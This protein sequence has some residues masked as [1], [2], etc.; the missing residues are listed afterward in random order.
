MHDGRPAFPT[1]LGAGRDVLVDNVL[2]GGG[3][4]LRLVED[5]RHS[6][7]KGVTHG[8]LHVRLDHLYSV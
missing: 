6:R 8:L 4:L 2:V 1:R 3:L 5:L 7:H